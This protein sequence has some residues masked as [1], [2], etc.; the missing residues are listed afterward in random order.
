MLRPTRFDGPRLLAGGFGGPSSSTFRGPVGLESV[1]AMSIGNPLQVG[2]VWEGG[3]GLLE[4]RV[5]RIEA[6]PA[7]S[8]RK[9]LHMSWFCG[10]R[11][12]GHWR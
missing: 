9:R 4:H 11:I 6:S 3:E 8:I 1:L 7:S 2:R 5:A 12:A 10:R